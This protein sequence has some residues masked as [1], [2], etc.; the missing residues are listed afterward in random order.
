MRG[1]SRSLRVLDWYR[2]QATDG[3]EWA[4][5]LGD[6]RLALGTSAYHSQLDQLARMLDGESHTLAN[7]AEALAVQ[8]LVEHAHRSTTVLANG[9]TPVDGMGGVEL[10]AESVSGGTN[11]GEAGGLDGVDGVG[12][13]RTHHRPDPTANEWLAGVHVPPAARTPR[14]R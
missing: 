6:D 2:L 9:D 13:D 12:P 8:E 5:L 1:R 4:D 14:V 7:F 10:A 11:L 3:G